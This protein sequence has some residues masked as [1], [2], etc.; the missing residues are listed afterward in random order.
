MDRDSSGQPEW[1]GVLSTG[2]PQWCC[3]FP[4]RSCVCVSVSVRFSVTSPVLFQSPACLGANIFAPVMRMQE[5]STRSAY[6]CSPCICIR[7]GYL[8]VLVPITKCVCQAADLRSVLTCKVG[9]SAIRKLG[10]LLDHSF[11]LPM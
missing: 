8:L 3:L 7:T 9:I 6:L 10:T 2:Q 11:G 4:L 1:E 5:T